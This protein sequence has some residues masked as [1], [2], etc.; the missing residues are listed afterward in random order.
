M[1]SGDEELGLARDPRHEAIMLADLLDNH[2]AWQR[3][4]AD[5]ASES[6]M[7]PGQRLDDAG[8]RRRADDEHIHVA[9]VAFLALGDGAEHERDLDGVTEWRQR[10]AKH[11]HQPRSLAKQPGE[12]GIDGTVTV[13]LVE[14]LIARRQPQQHARFG[15]ELQNV[16]TPSISRSRRA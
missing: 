3:D 4:R 5:L 16:P 10:L 15:Q 8:E 13:G 11:V 2:I 9:G 6:F 12:F 7:R 14:N 1:V